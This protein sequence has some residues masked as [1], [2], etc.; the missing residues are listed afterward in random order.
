MHLPLFLFVTG[1]W[2]LARHVIGILETS[3]ASQLE[4]HQHFEH[5][6]TYSEWMVSDFHF[7]VVILSAHSAALSVTWTAWLGRWPDMLWCV[8]WLQVLLH[9]TL[10]TFFPVM[11]NFT[12]VCDLETF[13]L[14]ILVCMESCS[15]PLF[16]KWR[17]EFKV[18]NGKFVSPMFRW[19]HSCCICW[20]SF[21]GKWQFSCMLIFNINV[22]LMVCGLCMCCISI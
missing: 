10:M 6:V 5:T 3:L 22:A 13:R 8:S 2:H 16:Y 1:V 4:L 15:V 12:R 14:W 20:L 18:E 9:S 21:N 7:I 11:I 17:S 19:F